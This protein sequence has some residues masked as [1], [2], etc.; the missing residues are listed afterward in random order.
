M[1]HFEIGKT[2]YM[3]YNTMMEEYSLIPVN[4]EHNEETI[5]E[6]PITFNADSNVT[7]WGN[8]FNKQVKAT[9]GET[10]YIVG[11]DNSAITNTND[12]FVLRNSKNQYFAMH[13]NTDFTGA[14]ERY[15]TPHDYAAAQYTI[16]FD[17]AKDGGTV[18][19]IFVNDSA[20]KIKTDKDAIIEEGK[21][22]ISTDF[23]KNGTLFNE[24]IVVPA[25]STVDTE[26]IS[27]RIEPTIWSYGLP[28]QWTKYVDPRVSG[29]T[30][31]A[32][33]D[34]PKINVGLGRRYSEVIISNPTIIEMAPGYMH[35]A[36]W[37][38]QDKGFLNDIE[39]FRETAG[40]D[41][42]R[43]LLSGFQKYPGRF[44]TIKPC[45][46]DKNYSVAD[47]NKR[48]SLF[49]GYI[50]Y[51]RYLMVIV[52]VFLARSEVQRV[53]GQTNLNESVIAEASTVIK[54]MSNGVPERNDYLMARPIPNLGATYRRIDWQFYNKHSGGYSVGGKIFNVQLPE[55]SGYFGGTTASDTSSS[56]SESSFDYIKFYL[57]GS[58]SAQD[59]FSTSVEDSFLGQLANSLNMAVKETAYWMASPLGKLFDEA[60]ATLNNIIDAVTI[61]NVSPLGGVFNV[62]EILGGGKYVFPQIITD[63]KYGKSI[64]CEC[65]FAAIYGDEEAMFANSLMP[66]MHLLAFALPHQVRTTQEMYTYPFIVKA[67]CR[68]LFN[69]EMGAITGFNVQRGG[70][71]NTLW[72]FNGASEVITVNFEVTPLINSLVMTSS[73]DGP[74]W[75]LKNTGLQEYMSAITAFDARNDRYDLAYDIMTAGIQ[76]ATQGKASNILT[77]IFN[78]GLPDFIYGF[79]RRLQNYDHGVIDTLTA[80]P[81]SAIEGLVAGV[82]PNQN[83]PD[84]DISGYDATREYTNVY[85]TSDGTTDATGQ[86]QGLI[87]DNTLGG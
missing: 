67:F 2:P 10:W 81:K 80:G 41:E 75:L 31:C 48:G 50:S 61:N 62:E 35:Y 85:M 52:S 19:D 83:I 57:S 26:I 18:Y 63:S 59:S 87:G 56:E 14:S 76:S 16:G 45:F 43:N 40:E 47:S 32:K 72:S 11:R 22:K 60:S 49:G 3:D 73:R 86:A 58:T 38:S 6:I 46:L 1:P 39:A 51:I 34:G 5:K 65:T 9:A 8:N 20:T 33:V 4:V 82:S 55:I 74:A 27:V 13:I 15:D 78:M 66:Y 21:R 84:P 71:D 24:F 77:P 64:S 37:M 53:T 42:I 7:L 44:Y 54:F 23:S 30:T 25:S 28:P 17:D 12:T 70:S 29:F 36:D 68:G 79:G 69:V